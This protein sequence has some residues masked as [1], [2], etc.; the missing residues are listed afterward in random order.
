MPK[1][2]TIYVL[3]FHTRQRQ[4]DIAISIRMSF[5][6]A[7]IVAETTFSEPKVRLAGCN[8]TILGV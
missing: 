3:H 2:V 8:C 1:Y 6:G 4:I 7:F 5:I